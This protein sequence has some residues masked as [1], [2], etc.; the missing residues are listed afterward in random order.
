MVAERGKDSKKRQPADLNGFVGELNALGT[1]TE[2]TLKDVNFGDRFDNDLVLR[3]A[4]RG[5]S[6]DDY[7][8]LVGRLMDAYEATTDKK[9]KD[10]YLN[11]WHHIMAIGENTLGI[12]WS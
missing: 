12:D 9:V 8:G 11:L 5:K 3:I 6:V 4:L 1:K 7:F 2:I 10:Q